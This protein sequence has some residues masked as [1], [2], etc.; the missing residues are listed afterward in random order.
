MRLA[1][2]QA[3]IREVQGKSYTWL[4]HWGIS[5]I[6]EAI[7]TIYNRASSTDADK[8]LAEDVKRKL[9]RRY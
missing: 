7:R 1:D 4:S 5:T 3:I 6:R 2:A 9:Y 8:E